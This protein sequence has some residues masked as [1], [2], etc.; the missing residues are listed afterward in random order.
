MSLPGLLQAQDANAEQAHWAYAAF[1]GTG[2]YK[3]DGN[4]EVFVLRIPPRW[5]YRDASIDASGQRQLGIEF[6]FPLTFGLHRLEE[7]EDFIDFD[8]IGTVSFNPGVEIEFPVT[9]RWRLRAYGHLGWG[10]EIDTSDSAWIFDAGIKSRFAF[11]SGKL[12]WALVNEVF[13]AGFN[14]KKKGPSS[15]GSDHLSGVM[16]GIDFSYPIGLR[17]GMGD[18]LKLNWDISFLRLANDALFSTV[19][20]PPD[21]LEDTWELG[22]ALAKQ[23]GP[24]KIWFLGFEQIGLSYR[25]DSSGN[26]QAITMNFRAPFTR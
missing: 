8:N 9:D 1:F 18:A 24:I 7:L 11:Q 6:H 12:E 17:S 15:G 19:K 22:I 20:P 2:W 25:F 23:A 5:Y 16:A 10:T 13:F 14:E 3:L 4:R 26:F 21:A